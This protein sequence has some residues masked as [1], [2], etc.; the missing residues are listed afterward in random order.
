MPNL[1]KG[2]AIL[3]ILIVLAIMGLLLA[4]VVPSLKT[5]RNN[6]LLKAVASDV[7]SAL[8]KAR[9]QTLSSINFSEYGVHFESD[10][11]VIFKGTVYSS[12]D[13]SNE[14]ISVTSPASIS[15][16]NLTGGAEGLYFNKLSGVPDKTG[17][18]TVS[19]AAVSRI[20]T[21]SA[22]GVASMD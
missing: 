5:M 21:I 4:V 13:A 22:T 3:E 17:T 15:D 1:K 19:V 2:F 7:F 12:S 6:Q 16:I 10:E 20:I 8:D 14:N 11:I 9:S 18:I